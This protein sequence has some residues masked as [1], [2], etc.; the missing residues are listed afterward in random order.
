MNVAGRKILPFFFFAWMLCVFTAN[1][2][3]TSIWAKGQWEKDGAV[4]IFN[5]VFVH[6]DCSLT[7]VEKIEGLEGDLVLGFG[8]PH[9]SNAL[10]EGVPSLKITGVEVDGKAV[11]SGVS[12]GRNKKGIPVELKLAAPGP[13][14]HAYTIRYTVKGRV[15][16][17][18]KDY[19]ELI[20]EPCSVFGPSGISRMSCAVTLPKG[21]ELLGQ[22]AT[23]GTNAGG[24]KKTYSF[25]GKSGAALY[26]GEAYMAPGEFFTVAARWSKGA[27]TPPGIWDE[28]YPDQKPFYDI[29]DIVTVQKDGTIEFDACLSGFT[30]KLIYSLNRTYASSSRFGEPAPIEFVSATV[31][32]KP[33]Q[34][35]V[36]M[37][38]AQEPSA[39]LIT[40][41]SQG[42]HDYVLHLKTTD[43]V[44]FN[45]KDYD[46]LTWD[47]GAPFD[48]ARVA[49]T[50]NLPEGA[51]VLGQSARLGHETTDHKPVEMSKSDGRALFRGMGY[52]EKGQS[53]AVTVRFSKGIVTAS[54]SAKAMEKLERY[55]WV[56]FVLTA[57]FCTA[58]WWFFGKDP[59]PKTIVPRFYP[60]VLSDGTIL[61]PA[62]VAYVHDSARLKSR[63]FVGLLLNL[64]V[65]KALS[66]SGSGT[67]KDP[68][69]LS[70]GKK[71]AASVK[72]YQDGGRNDGRPAEAD[73]NRRWNEKIS[74]GK[75]FDVAERSVINRL[76]ASGEQHIFGKQS[77]W[78]IA[79]AR[80]DAY[81]A[82]SEDLR[83]TWR[84]R[85]GVVL[86]MHF[87]VYL[88]LIVFLAMSG[89]M[90]GS[91]S[92]AIVC[93]IVSIGGLLSW[94]YHSTVHRVHKFF[95]QWEEMGLA[96]M[97]A[98]F[99]LCLLI[100]MIL[101]YDF[102][103]IPNDDM[104]SFSGYSFMEA[105]QPVRII[106]VPVLIAYLYRRTRSWPAVT[107]GPL[108]F[109][110]FLL[111]FIMLL[112]MLWAMN[113]PG[114]SGAAL[115]LA[116]IS[117]T[118]F[119]PIM[120]QPSPK[121]LQLMADIEGFGMYIKAAETERLNLLNAP[122]RTPHEFQRVMPYAV[123]LG[124]ENAWGAKFTDLA[125]QLHFKGSIGTLD[126][127]Q[128]RLNGI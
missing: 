57:L 25:V 124:L 7:V 23:L 16:T 1:A 96:C 94:L 121:A 101:L 120:K 26:R 35:T 126:E 127:F 53:F 71:G 48:R 34:A 29:H 81:L 9:A 33:A 111:G 72:I 39:I 18:G 40:P 15:L 24:A 5:S 100:P 45:S 78:S 27:V 64:A 52:M 105:W 2:G 21:A 10:K 106:L 63:G 75:G 76:L 107:L 38:G 66:I 91:G 14:R 115:L 79:M 122:E 68:Y 44:L 77:S 118:L 86:A 54:S 119:L 84:L 108:K 83:G 114:T 13:G 59:R 74:Q 82:V 93:A 30:G 60:P 89:A 65:Q 80:G 90:G 85:A 103:I 8:R 92:F 49:C 6:E 70:P 58:M 95:I 36:S 42:P 69:I 3:E 41:P 113:F 67:K 110:G 12:V 50:I 51:Q 99:L 31:D 20:W 98:F 22:E 123:A 102:I 56:L 73:L 17:S 109:L 104:N 11:P 62:Q 61:S 87:I 88:A 125:A 47:V 32:G 112:G 128:H 43:C 19:D 117:P 116:L 4:N 97:G 55:A 28:G 37:N 46:E